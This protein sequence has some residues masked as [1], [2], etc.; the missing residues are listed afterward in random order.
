MSDKLV[1]EIPKEIADIAGISQDEINDYNL[2]IWVFNLYSK[3]RIS[4]SK[5]SQL[6]GIKIDTFLKKFRKTHLRRAG[7]PNNIEEANADA[8]AI[9]HALNQ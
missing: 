5:A 9:S 7:G 4:L 2:E 6:L 8:E 3:G 1:V